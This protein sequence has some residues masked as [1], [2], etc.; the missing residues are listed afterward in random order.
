[1]P[2]AVPGRRT[3]AQPDPVRKDVAYVPIWLCL[4]EPLAADINRVI[5]MARLER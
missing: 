3:P 5:R 4:H 2:A 1:V